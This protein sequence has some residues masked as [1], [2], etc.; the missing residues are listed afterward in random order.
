[1]ALSQP[2]R[3]V[4]STL[5]KFKIFIQ[6]INLPQ[7]CP[8]LSF[9]VTSEKNVFNTIEDKSFHVSFR[10]FSFSSLQTLFF[11]YSPFLIHSTF[12]SRPNHSQSALMPSSILTSFKNSIHFLPNTTPLLCSLAQSNFFKTLI[13][14]S[15]SK[16]SP[17]IH[18][19]ATLIVSPS[20]QSH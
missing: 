17:P 20:L 12:P 18:F 1:M 9:L 4:Y 6:S 7:L 5:K 2:N 15:E 3:K 14:N 19:S 8:L 10:S 11:N 13:L 16:F